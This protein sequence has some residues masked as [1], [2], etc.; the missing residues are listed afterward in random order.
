MPRVK[1]APAKGRRPFQ[2]GEMVIALEAA[3]VEVDGESFY[4][5]TGQQF[6]GDHPAVVATPSVFMPADTPSDE[7]V[8]WLQERPD[9]PQHAPTFNLPSAPPILPEDALIVINGIS[10]TVR[11]L[12]VGAVVSISDPQV[13]PMVKEWP[14][15]FSWYKP[16]TP[17]DLDRLSA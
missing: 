4:I 12:R 8:L 11:Q 7:V 2:D 6:H 14:S 17:E 3:Y 13:W 15:F 5:S 10:S 9:P 1:P 16:V